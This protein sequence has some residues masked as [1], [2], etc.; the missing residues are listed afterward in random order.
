M[1]LDCL[2]DYIHMH[3]RG[4]KRSRNQLLYCACLLWN[5]FWW[6]MGWAQLALVLVMFHFCSMCSSHRVT[7]REQRHDDVVTDVPSHDGMIMDVLKH[8]DVVTDVPR[9][10]GT[11]IDV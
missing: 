8:Y 9:H 2:I 1:H 7:A 11:M 5:L 6:E 10:D 3:L 4:A